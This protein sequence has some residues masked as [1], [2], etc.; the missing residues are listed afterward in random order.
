MQLAQL[1]VTIKGLFLALGVA[2]LVSCGSGDEAGGG[3]QCGGAEDSGVCLSVDFITPVDGGAGPLFT[4]DTIV[5]ADCDGDPATVDPEPG[6]FDHTADVTF[7]AFLVN[8]AQ[9]V[10]PTQITITNYDVSYQLAAGSADPGPV[11][12]SRG[13]LRTAI[14]IPVGGT[15]VVVGP[16]ALF[17]IAQKSDAAIGGAIAAGDHPSYIVTYVFRGQDDFGQNVDAIGS[18]LV[19]IGEYLQNC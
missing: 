3:G 17:D 13:G 5:S 1:K 12:P 14:V 16:F 19:N 10:V 6:I 11:I 8:P 4:V 9:T 15:L 2:G 18:T 7:S